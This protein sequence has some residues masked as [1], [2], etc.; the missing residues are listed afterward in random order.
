MCQDDCAGDI[1]DFLRSTEKCRNDKEMQ[2]NVVFLQN[3][4]CAYKD[5]EGK[6]AT[7]CAL[8][9]YSKIVAPLTYCFGWWLYGGTDCPVFL[10]ATTTCTEALKTAVE[11]YGCCYQNLFG[12]EEFIDAIT[13]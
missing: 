6:P 7:S 13:R 4:L 8:Q 9:N 12:R 5:G 3:E 2:D 10:S 11:D 1:I